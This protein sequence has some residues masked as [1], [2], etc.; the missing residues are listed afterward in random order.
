METPVAFT[1]DWNWYFNASNIMN[2]QLVWDTKDYLET[3]RPGVFDDLYFF[4][5]LYKQVKEIPSYLD[6]PV[7]FVEKLNKLPLT[8]L[9]RY[10]MFGIILK[11]HGGHPI[12]NLD[13]QYNTILK[14][15]ERQFLRAYS[16]EDMPE[17]Q[18]CATSPVTKELLRNA[19]ALTKAAVIKSYYFPES[20][21]IDKVNIDFEELPD[22]VIQKGIIWKFEKQ[23]K[24]SENEYNKWKEDY[25][26]L[27]ESVPEEHILKTITKGIEYAKKIYQFHLQNE[28]S[29]PQKC[30]LNQSWQRRIVI[31]ENLLKQVKPAPVAIL[32]TEETQGKNK[33]F[34]SAR[35]VLAI[36]YLLIEA[37]ISPVDNLTVVARFVQFVTGRE[38]NAKRI[39][40]TTIYKRV[41]QPFKLNDDELQKDLI[42]V[43]KFF[44]TLNLSTI[45][46][47]IDQEIIRCQS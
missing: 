29:D 13:T 17:K 12:N 31:A 47:Q 45:V 14:F 1:Y 5:L 23:H 11:W 18:F 20:K 10:I 39:Q 24:Q 2:Q 33:G 40:D 32:E 16:G 36:H 44:E 43:K 15:I 35:Q 25:Y 30:V 38:I 6:K 42:Y 3:Q 9:Q 26:A 37:G 22:W 4:N 8:E 41:V 21:Y 27:F 19:E 46:A 28:C 34:T 7:D